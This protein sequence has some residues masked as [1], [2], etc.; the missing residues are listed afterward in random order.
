MPNKVEWV[1]GMAS[2]YE[3]RNRTFR[4]SERSKG[5][6]KGMMGSKAVKG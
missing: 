4:I 5:K 1:R 2:E 6:N 3:A